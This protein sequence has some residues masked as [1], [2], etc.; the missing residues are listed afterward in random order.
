MGRWKGTNI[1]FESMLTQDVGLQEL[2]QVD[3]WPG[4]H[5]RI[6]NTQHLPNSALVLLASLACTELYPQYK[7][8]A[9]LPFGFQLVRVPA[10]GR[11]FGACLYLS[12]EASNI[13]L[14]AWFHRGRT[15]SGV[16]YG[17]KDQENENDAV[18]QFATQLTD[19]PPDCRDRLVKGISVKHADIEPHFLLRMFFQQ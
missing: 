2:M 13:D 19:M 8:P 17:K 16:A 14:F 6:G 9:R 18:M 4:L 11:C 5:A 10:D 15:K 1:V 12:V 3:Q 7:L